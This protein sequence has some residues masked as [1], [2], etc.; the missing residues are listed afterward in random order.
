MPLTREVDRLQNMVVVLADSALVDS[1]AAAC[2]DPRLRMLSPLLGQRLPAG[3]S[4]EIMGTAVLPEITRYQV[5]VR[6]SGI[7]GGWSTVNLYRG[8]TKLDQLAKWNTEALSPGLYD[9]R[10]L[11]VDN[12]NIRLPRTPDCAIAIELTP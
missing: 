5:D 3:V 9:L 10:L 12:N 11:A 6:P 4:V 2:P 8:T 7:E 1:N